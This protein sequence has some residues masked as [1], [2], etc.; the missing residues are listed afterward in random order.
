MTRGEVVE[1][2]TANTPT[3]VEIDSVVWL[4]CCQEPAD[5]MSENERKREQ[6]KQKNKKTKSSTTHPQ[7][8]PRALQEPQFLMLLHA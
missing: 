3:N 4:L 5:Q 6:K 2:H 8:G 1:F 7:R